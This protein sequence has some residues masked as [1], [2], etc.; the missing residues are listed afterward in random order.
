LISQS[1]PEIF[2][3][4]VWSCP[5]SSLI[6]RVGPPKVVPKWLCLP[7]ITSRGKVS[8]RYSASSRVI[9]A[10]ALNFWPIFEFIIIK[11]CSGDPV[12]GECG[13]ASLGHSLPHVTGPKCSLPKN[14]ILGG[15]PCV[16]ITFFLVDQSSP[17]F[18]LTWRVC[19]WLLAFA[20]FDISMR[21]RAR[22]IRDQSLK[23]FE[24]APNFPDVFFCFLKF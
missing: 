18:C 2:L 10:H 6:L 5:E 19:S 24:I 14:L 17:I 12:P 7:R 15:S 16:P 3:I 22:D 8:W 11:N 20:I 4:K 9:G 23:L 13:L 1:I 21:T